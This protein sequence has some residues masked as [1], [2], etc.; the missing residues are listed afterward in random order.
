VRKLFASRSDDAEPTPV[1]PAPIVETKIPAMPT[2]SISTEPAPAS[3]TSVSDSTVQ[4]RFKAEREKLLGIVERLRQAPDWESLANTTVSEI[5]KHLKADRVL[6]YRFGT[7]ENGIVV[8]EVRGREWTPA[9]QEKLPATAFGLDERNQYL[10]QSYVELRAGESASGSPTPYQAQLLDRFQV[11]N[12]LS[13]P[14]V[15]E[16]EVWGLL[17]V[18]QCTQAS[19]WPEEDINLLYQVATELTLV[20]Q[21]LEFRL[22]LNRQSEQEIAV[23]KVVDKI[24]RSMDINTV[25]NTATQE[26]RQI[27]QA[28]RV[29][30]YR[31]NPDWSGTF[32]AESVGSGWNSILG[33][34]FSAEVGNCTSLTGLR[35]SGMPSNSR[36]VLLPGSKEARSNEGGFSIDDVYAMGFPAD[37]LEAMEMIGAKA[38]MMTA[39]FVGSKLWGMLSIYQNSG[40]RQ[41]QDSERKLLAQVGSQ[42][43]I[44]IQQAE[45]IQR[46]TQTSE[47]EQAVTRVVDK[48]RRSLDVNTVF[49]NTTQEV[50]QLLQVDRVVVYRLNPDWSGT[51]VA[52]SLGSGWTSVLGK[53]FGAQVGDCKSLTTLRPEGVSPDEG[54]DTRPIDVKYPRNNLS[55]FYLNDVYAVGLPA[56]YLEVMELLGAKAYLTTSIFVGNKLWGLLAAYQNS[57]PR[58]WKASEEKWLYQIGVQLGIALQQAATLEQVQAQAQQLIES[59]E[60]EKA[61]KEQLQQRAVQMLMAVRP[62]FMGD[63]TVRAPITEDEVGTIAD[64]YNNTL[65]S[66]RKLVVQVQKAA[67]NVADTSR[68]SEGSI[69]GLSNQAQYQFQELMNTLEQIRE[70]SKA[71]EAVTVNAEQVGLAVQQANETVKAGDAAMNRTVDGILGI[72]ETVAETGKKI[73]RLSESSQKISRVVNL[74]SNFTAQTQLLALNASIEATRAG[75]YG[76]GFAVVADEVRSLARQSASATTEIEKLVQEIQRETIDVAGAMEQ[77][78][79][80]VVEG[81]NLVNETR[82]TLNEIVTA[83]SQI[84][85]LV[86]GITQA[87]KE[88]TQQSQ[89]VTQTMSDLAVTATKTSESAVQ[90]STSFQE[91]LKMAGE[92]Q[93]S[94]GQFKVN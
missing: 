23:S 53:I 57:G 48:I 49:S 61:A 68:S 5:C 2:P 28:D 93:A 7:P 13:V 42:F 67:G 74:I 60:R 90:I 56:E 58:E 71:T 35:P 36:D 78:I 19:P 1:S 27:L 40:S 52:E 91:L 8:A 29:V 43:G 89:S 70:M 80:Q 34:G 50:R 65:Q 63:L 30:V 10:T 76:R 92:L 83:T 22:K 73:K 17:V 25:F 20:I 47:Q 66:L 39:L 87:A 69:I 55:G 62:A 31:F 94:V 16:H 82:Q 64:A 15:V 81:T 51:F 84:S 79:Q 9:L 75:E 12:S 46:L 24:R 32:V 41:W 4:R 21:Q 11:K 86:A 3:Y 44:A 72:R 77:G 59:A 6:V 26:V 18:H 33:K 54:V 85:Q 45:F 14:I 37:Y 38:Y 88:Q